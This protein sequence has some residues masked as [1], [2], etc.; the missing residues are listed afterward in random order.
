VAIIIF[1]VRVFSFF[2]QCPDPGGIFY[3]ADK[4]FAYGTSMGK[5]RTPERPP[6]ISKTITVD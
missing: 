2:S 1:N 5:G 3:M 6:N 4:R